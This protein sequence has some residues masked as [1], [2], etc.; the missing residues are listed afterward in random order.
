MM[1]GMV[2]ISKLFIFCKCLSK[3]IIVKLDIG[4]S[5]Y[6]KKRIISLAAVKTVKNLQ[7]P[8]FIFM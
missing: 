6:I 1:T 4:L 7:V 5:E 8:S 3:I 2:K